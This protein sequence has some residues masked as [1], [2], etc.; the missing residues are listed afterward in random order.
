MAEETDFTIHPGTHLGP[1]YLKIAN[2]PRALAFYRDVLGLSV[3]PEPGR[4]ENARVLALSAEPAPGPGENA[5]V[6]ALSAGRD[7][8]LIV[9]HEVPGARP[10]PPRSTGLYHFAILAPTRLDLAQVLRRLDETG[11]PLDGASDHGVSEALYLSDPDGNGIEIYRDRPREEWPRRSDELRMGV[12]ALDLDD[13]LRDLKHG[14]VHWAG[15]PAGTTIGHVHLHVADLHEAEVFYRDGLGFALMQ[16]MGASAIFVSAG[17]YHHHV[18]ANI[19]AGVG[20][21]P[22]PTDAVGL[23]QFTILLPDRAEL[24][25]TVD[26]LRQVDAQLEDVQTGGA[27]PAARTQDPSGNKIVLSI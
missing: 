20:A 22:P 9:L 17:G 7:Q 3:Q 26:H 14:D 1:V 24:A 13:F 10:K 21:P 2:M 15:L 19:W 18:G 27:A 25:R 11:Y 12:E 6:L 8:S 4:G 23:E 16:R 5:K